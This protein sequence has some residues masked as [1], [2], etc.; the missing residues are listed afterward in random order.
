MANRRGEGVVPPVVLAEAP[1]AMIDAALARKRALQD[2]VALAGPGRTPLVDFIR[3]G[4]KVVDPKPY[5]HNWH[6]AA[7]SEHLQAVSDGQI[8]KLIIAEPPSYAKSLVTSVFWPAW[9]WGPNAHPET[10]FLCTSYGGAEAAPALRDAERARQLMTSPWFQQSWGMGFNLSASQNAKGFYKND[11]HGQRLSAGMDG[12][13]SGGR[14]DFII[15]DDPTKTDAAGNGLYQMPSLAEILHASSVWES[16]LRTRALDDG[17]AVVLIMQRLHEDDLAGYF[18][19][20]DGWTILR[21]PALYEVEHKCRVFING[22]LFF[23]DP[24]TVDGEP[25][26]PARVLATN[27]AYARKASQP[28][29]HAAQDQQRPAPLEG[30]M[31]KRFDRYDIYPPILDDIIMVVDCAFKDGEDNSWVVMQCWGRRDTT[32]YL[33]DQVRDHLDLPATLDALYAFCLR[34]P[35]AG[36]KYVEDKANGTGVVQMLRN[37]VPGLMSTSA[38]DQGDLCLKKFCMGSKEAKLSAVAPYYMA[39]N[40][41]IPS[42]AYLL[43]SVGEDWTAEY[44]HELTTFPRSRFNDQVDASA[45]GVWK[46]LSSFEGHVNVSE[47]LA[48]GVN[49]GQMVGK[50]EKAYGGIPPPSDAG[51][52]L[53]R[54]AWGRNTGATGGDW[55]RK[56]FGS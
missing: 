6:I 47:L 22:Q 45:M 30:G 53:E 2:P 11:H 25:L 18:I 24:R 1:L 39:G 38:D 41:K 36:A 28:W 12:S 23:E 3:G 32:A 20:Q 9:Q 34:H 44:V 8:S 43:A 21:L 40:V 29:I 15:I 42:T 46:L 16:T 10:R 54:A 48:A 51:F 17:S 27:E 52:D 7:K 13:I 35:L 49:T 37:R 50:F 4:W 55:R 33:L 5:L 31:I 56:A 26:H 14:A 19:K